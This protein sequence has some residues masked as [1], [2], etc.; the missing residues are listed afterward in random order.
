MRQ[1]GSA[2]GIVVA[3]ALI[4]SRILV[5]HGKRWYSSLPFTLLQLR[6]AL[7]ARAQPF[8]R[9]RLITTGS[10]CPHLYLFKL[11]VSR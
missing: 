4:V 9:Q 5:G 11:P 3:F 7:W 6:V 8:N 1:G 2:V 10:N